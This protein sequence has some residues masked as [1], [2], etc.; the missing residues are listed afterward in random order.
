[1]ARILIVEDERWQGKLCL[2]ELRAEGYEVDWIMS[3]EEALEQIKKSKYDLIILDIYLPG[4]DG[5]ET[6]GQVLSK[7]RKIPVILYSAYST[8]QDNFLSWAADAYLVKSADL[9]ELK[10]TIRKVLESS[11]NPPAASP[12][13]LPPE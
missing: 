8:Y 11:P 6:M 10:A 2:E 3:G 4:M 9:T 12:H 7:D 1:M 5:L 13:V